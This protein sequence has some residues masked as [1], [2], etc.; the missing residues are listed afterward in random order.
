MQDT[1]EGIAP[2][3]LGELAKLFGYVKADENGIPQVYA[4]YDEA[5]DPQD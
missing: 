4:D 3:S 1:G 5:A 2:L